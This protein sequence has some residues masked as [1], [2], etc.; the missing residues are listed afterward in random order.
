MIKHKVNTII[1]PIN[2]LRCDKIEINH[3][4]SSSNKNPSLR[5]NNVIISINT[6]N[7]IN[8]YWSS[9]KIN[10]R[11]AHDTSCSIRGI[12]KIFLNTYFKSLF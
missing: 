10:K 1:F 9:L 12:E 8:K 11:E 2:W 4:K 7:V 5:R 6:I 3:V